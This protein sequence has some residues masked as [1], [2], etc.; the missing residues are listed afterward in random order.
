MPKS[1]DL[2]DDSSQV[3]NSLWFSTLFTDE[4][5]VDVIDCAGYDEY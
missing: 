1:V 5:V 3:T 2:P 4:I